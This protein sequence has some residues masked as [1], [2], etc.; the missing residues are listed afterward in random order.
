MKRSR[1]SFFEEDKSSHN[2]KPKLMP[3][4]DYIINNPGL[5]KIIEKIFFNLDFHDLQACQLINKSSKEILDNPMFWLKKWKRIIGG[6]LSQKNDSDWKKAIQKIRGDTD[7]ESNV[8]SYIKKIIQMG[9]FV[10][11]PCF[12]DDSAIDKFYNGYS[13]QEVQ[14]GFIENDDGFL[15]IRWKVFYDH[16]LKTN[17]KYG[18]IHYSAGCNKANLIK[19]FAPLVKNPNYLN[20]YRQTPMGVAVANGDLDAVKSLVP[21]TTNANGKDISGMSSIQLAIMQGHTEIVKVLAPLCDNYNMYYKCNANLN[22]DR[23]LIHWAILFQDE[24]PEIIEILVNFMDNPNAP[25]K[26]GVTPVEMAKN[27]GLNDIVKIL[28]K[29]TKK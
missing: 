18:L 11:V 6:I 16:F 4:M 21:F 25:D 1:N 9:H 12:I 23:N 3:N 8:R 28:E 2:K 24:K 15:Q 17:E 10:D 27:Q 14:E 13:V 29:A 7:L 26:F 19:I 20:Y 5:Q 22:P